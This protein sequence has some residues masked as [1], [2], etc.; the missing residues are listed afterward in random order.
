MTIKADNITH[1]KNLEYTFREPMNENS[2][3]LEFIDY[4]DVNSVDELELLP[5]QLLQDSEVNKLY[6]DGWSVCKRE[7]E[8][9]TYINRITSFLLNLI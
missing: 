1:S 3:F 5:V 9:D 7:K 2:K 6:V 4:M 8:P